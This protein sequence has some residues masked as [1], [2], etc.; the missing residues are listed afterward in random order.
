MPEFGQMDH[1][2]LEDSLKRVQ[3]HVTAR[4][5]DN[6]DKCYTFFDIVNSY[7]FSGHTC[8]VDTVVHV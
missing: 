8:L 2:S 5:S 1:A 3:T 4:S 7:L 6:L